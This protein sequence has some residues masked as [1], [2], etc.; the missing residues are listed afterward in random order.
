[1][2]IDGCSEF[3]ET[4]PNAD[5]RA[6]RAGLEKGA[7]TVWPCQECGCAVEDEWPGAEAEHCCSDCY[8]RI[9]ARIRRQLL[10]RALRYLDQHFSRHAAELA[11]EIGK[12]L[13][14]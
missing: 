5:R 14:R 11:D 7:F 1:M 2:V 4:V 12:E 13:K 8:H 6:F 10:E 9:R 3:C